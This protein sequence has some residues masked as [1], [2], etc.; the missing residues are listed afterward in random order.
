[1]TIE[2]PKLTSGVILSSVARKILRNIFPRFSEGTHWQ[3]K[4]ISSF[5]ELQAKWAP[6]SWFWTHLP[7]QG[8]CR[9]GAWQFGLSGYLPNLLNL[10]RSNLP[11]HYFSINL[12]INIIQNLFHH[13]WKAVYKWNNR[14]F[15]VL[16][17]NHPM[18]PFLI[19]FFSALFKVTIFNTYNI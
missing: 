8:S 5:Y 6:F 12:R 11:S 4:D 19:T 2:T 13:Q 7:L 3:M 1:M 10:I 16:M 18:I 15:C 14:V 17:A 9:W